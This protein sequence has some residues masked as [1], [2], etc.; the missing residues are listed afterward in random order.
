MIGPIK[1]CFLTY[2]PNGQSR[3]IATIVFNKPGSAVQAA[4]QLNGVKVDN[5]P[6]KVVSPKPPSMDGI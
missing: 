4:T 1:T 6:M 3:G 5:R 2:G